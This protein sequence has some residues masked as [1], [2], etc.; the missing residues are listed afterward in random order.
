MA[1]NLGITNPTIG[2]SFDTWGQSNDDNIAAIN[3][4]FGDILTLTDTSGTVTLSQSQSNYAAM[5]FT[6]SGA[7]LVTV[8]AIDDIGRLWFV[9]N[10]RASG[11]VKFQCADGLGASVTLAAA[12]RRFIYS[13]GTDCIDAT[14]ATLAIASV[15][16]LQAALDA[17]QTL[18]ASLTAYAAL[19]TAADK[20]VYYSAADTP[21]TYDLTSFGRALGG[22][23]SEAAL[24]SGVNLEANTDFYAPAGT[25]VALADGGTGAS[26]TDPNADRI[27]FWDDSAG[28]VTWLVPTGAAFISA[29]ALYV[30]ETIA[31]AVSDETTAITTGT[32]KVTFRM[33]YAFT[34]T[35]VK[36]SLST[37]SSSGLP[38]FD[39]NE[40]GVTILST[41][42]S[43]D[44]NEKTSTTAAT[45][46]VVSDA[47]LAADAEMT[48]DI[49]VAGTGAKG[50]KVYLIGY[51]TA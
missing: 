18:D 7:S 51:R 33:P 35:S 48:I 26:L 11:S 30:Y 41:K 31:I 39:I 10:A 28:A 9:N 23:A 20:G 6:G 29:T 27:M 40:G 25:D 42:L 22:Y 37:A 34:I 47:A 16:G 24:K 46:A 32:A 13:D 8:A 14:L 49:D 43:I 2:G 45:A 19:V 12:D 44:A 17:K 1:N 50:A 3:K 4:A 38:T 15:T 21:V 5:K 36:A